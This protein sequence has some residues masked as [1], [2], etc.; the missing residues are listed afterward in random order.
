MEGPDSTQRSWK[1]LHWKWHSL[2]KSGQE[3]NTNYGDCGTCIH[4]QTAHVRSA[5]QHHVWTWGP[6][7]NKREDHPILLVAR[8]GQFHQQTSKKLWQM[9][10]NKEGEE[11]NNKFC[12]STAS[13]H[14]AQPTYP[15]GSLWA[16]EN[17]RVRQEIHHV[18]HRCFFKI[19][20]AGGTPKQGGRHS[21]ICTLQQMALQTWI[22]Q[23]DRVWQW[24]RVLQLCSQQNAQI[25]ECHKDQYIT[26]SPA[27]QCTG[28]S[29]QQNNCNLF[30]DP[31]ICK[32]PGLGA[33]HGPNG[34]RLQHK[35]PQ[36]VEGNPI[37]NHI[38]PRSPDS[39]LQS[40]KAIW[41]RNR[42]RIVSKNGDKPRIHETTGQRAHRC[43]NQKKHAGSWQK[44]Q[45]TQF[46]GRRHSPNPGQGFPHQE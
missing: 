3:W 15:H 34:I 41:G 8:N 26:I 40:E 18:Y 9:S 7:Q 19:C 37:Q 43:C 42:H 28:G 2:E 14:H 29:L 11:A 44:G 1:L 4:C 13:M 17:F 6:V 25:D 30:E 21:C 38:W 5:W 33:L 20:G 12:F 46:Q 16:T 27:N 23:W 45:S 35:F 22:A 32:Y 24:Q 31:G 10:E 36:D 39:Q